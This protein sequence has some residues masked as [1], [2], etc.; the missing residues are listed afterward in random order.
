MALANIGVAA[1]ITAA[2]SG[3][4]RFD[5]SLAAEER[6]SAVNGIWLCQN[7][8]KEVDDDVVRF[9]AELLRAWKR[10]AEEDA[11]AMLGVPISAQSLDI[12]IQVTLHRAPDDSL[13]VT[14]ATNLPDGTKLFVELMKPG[15]T[16]LLGQVQTVVLNGLLSAVGFK[17]GNT[18][19]PHCWLTVEVLAYFNGPWKQPQAVMDIVGT[20]GQHLIGR[21]SEPLHPE[22]AES[23]KR[24]RAA[25]DCVAPPLSGSAERSGAECKVAIDVVKNA[26]LV[27]DGR[28]SAEPVGKVVELYMSSPGL[29]PLNG[30]NARA[31]PNG[32]FHVIYS[33]W[34][35]DQPAAADWLTI[36]E[37]NEV[38]YHNL[39]GKYMSWSPDY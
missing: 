15:E 20:G 10:H 13:V 3:G 19:H 2:A 38:R 4:P 27:V 30:W 31:L 23:E 16:K 24:F 36:P 18:P 39:Y 22:F 8:A 11:R 37:T 26:V 5:A 28:I 21:F 32:A 12:T 29:R 6:R 35:G 9:P 34:N 1:H 14:G 7:H 33:Y 25:F 17:N